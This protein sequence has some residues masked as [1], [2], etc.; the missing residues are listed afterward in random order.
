MVCD[1][2]LMIVSDWIDLLP[3]YAPLS[4]PP[5]ICTVPPD[6]VASAR[7]RP[8]GPVVGCNPV[9]LKVWPKLQLGGRLK[10]EL[11]FRL[12]LELASYCA[13]RPTAPCLRW[14]NGRVNCFYLIKTTLFLLHFLREMR[15]MKFLFRLWLWFMFRV[16]SYDFFL[17][18]TTFWWPSCACATHTHC[19]WN[20]RCYTHIL[21][22]HNCFIFII[23]SNCLITLLMRSAITP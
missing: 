20:H 12:R 7:R 9:G 2:R 10:L 4:S 22:H 5:F 3:A 19:T 1:C 21:L 16:F 23:I 14:A 15:V 18:Y 11:S 13:M 6:P 17:V 8:V